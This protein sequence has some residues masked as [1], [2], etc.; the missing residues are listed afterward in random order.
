LSNPLLN[1]SVETQVPNSSFWPNVVERI[2]RGDTSGMEDMYRAFSKGIRFL[3]SRQL[4]RQDLDDKVHDVFVIVAEAIRNGELRE[5]ERLMGYVHTVVRRLVAGHI[6]HAIRKRNEFV[7]ANIDDSLLDKRPNPEHETSDRQRMALAM[8]VLKSLPERD[9]G[10]LTR[11]YLNEETP[12][13]ICRD[14]D[15]SETQFR[16]IKSRAKTRFAELGKRRLAHRRSGFVA[17]RPERH[18]RAC[19]A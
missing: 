10:V 5:P 7:D 19:P 4:G 13:K 11:F 14:M 9:R 15:L 12:E 1:L 17:V 3:L 6:H 16:L 18:P 2:R 8:S